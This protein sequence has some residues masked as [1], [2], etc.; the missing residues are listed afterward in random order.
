MDLVEEFNSY[1]QQCQS[2]ARVA[3]DPDTKATWTKLAA[4][5]NTGCRQS[6]YARGL[7]AAHPGYRSTL[8]PSQQARA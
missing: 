8:P 2:M 5:S 4:H 7:G 6:A 3:R 1:K